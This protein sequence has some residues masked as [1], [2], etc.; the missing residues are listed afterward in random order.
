MP[1]FDPVAFAAEMRQLVQQAV[2]PAAIANN[3][4]AK[5]YCWYHGRK[6]HSG[7]HCTKMAN[8]PDFTDAMRSAN[9]P[10]KTGGSTFGYPIN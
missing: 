8:N 5:P 1:Q 7:K 4:T 9:K 6:G 3:G 10:T 2:A